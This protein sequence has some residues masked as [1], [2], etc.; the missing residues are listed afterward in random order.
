MPKIML[1]H[2]KWVNMYMHLSWERQEAGAFWIWWSVKKAF[3]KRS[4]NPCSSAAGTAEEGED[5]W[6]KPNQQTDQELDIHFTLKNWSS[7]RL[8]SFAPGHITNNVET[9]VSLSSLDSM[10]SFV[11]TELKNSFAHHHHIPHP[12]QTAFFSREKTLNHR[13]LWKERA[14]FTLFLF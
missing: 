11:S 8:T 2:K 4:V 1:T 7:N 6:K 14:I 10:S 9:R 12:I 5:D 3:W 13:L